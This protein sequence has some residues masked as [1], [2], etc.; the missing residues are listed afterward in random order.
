MTTLY[1]LNQLH[2]VVRFGGKVKIAYF[3]GNTIEFLNEED[4][5]RMYKNKRWI[6]I[7]LTW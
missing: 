1:K 2:A 5:V 4:F 3:R 6:E 7:S